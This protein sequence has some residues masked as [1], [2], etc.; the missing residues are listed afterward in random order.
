MPTLPPRTTPRRL[1]D[2]AILGPDLGGA[3]AAA[4]ICRKGVRAVLCPMGAPPVARES[5][6][7]L[8]PAA[9]PALP[10]LRQLSGASAQL[11]EL[12]LG[13]ELQRIA[14]SPTH[15]AFQILTDKLRLSLPDEPRRRQ[16]ELRRELSDVAA[17]QSLAAL[18]ALE[19]LGRAWDPFVAEPPPWP[20]RGYF[21][22]RKLRKVLPTPPALPEG[23][24]G[25]A[26]H[27]VAPFAASLVGASAP[28][29]VAREA[30]A[31]FRAPMRLWG[32]AAQLTELLRKKAQ[33]AGA[34]ILAETP[35][36]LRL[37]RKGISFQ[38]AG[39]EVRAACVILACSADAIAQLL[40]AT[41][42]AE[43]QLLDAAALPVARKVTLAH[44][45][46]RPQGLPVALEDAALF[47]GHQIGPLLLSSTPAR[48]GR[49]ETAGERLLTV[50]RVSDAGFADGEGFLSTVRKALEPVLPF[51]DRH[52]LHEAADLSPGQ[53]PILRPHG[54]ETEPVGLRP[55]SDLHER[56]L[57]ASAA[58][59]PGF[60]L[61]GQ[62]LA[63]RAAA[64][65][66]MDL[67]S[68]KAVSV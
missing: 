36:E 5:D 57:F 6:G 34:E 41:G 49:G 22:K 18:D 38:V 48:R 31:F 68:R 30:A 11:D 9:F 33:E 55:V 1:Y 15:G 63:A 67:S 14:S 4:L 44:Y 3:A 8:L 2:V 10:P 7:W 35:T 43:R 16:A 19:T 17:A 13:Q 40:P 37:D 45:V 47:L 54:D 24:I 65:Q 42:R 62:L 64:D 23:L 66:A 53:P 29:A 61:E 32:G 28:E 20:P 39:G 21:E 58:T 56:V 51:F 25:D 50:A 59:Y 27:A 60:G 12:G 52:I 46:V 26:L